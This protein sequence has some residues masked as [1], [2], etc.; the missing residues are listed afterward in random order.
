MTGEVRNPAY[1]V[2]LRAARELFAEGTYTS[3]AGA[4]DYARLNALLG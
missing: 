2:A 1:A 4:L 3:L